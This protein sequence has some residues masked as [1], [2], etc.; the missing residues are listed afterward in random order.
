[1]RGRQRSDHA[2]LIG[3]AKDLGLVL[4]VVEAIEESRSEEE[5]QQVCVCKRPLGPSVEA[6]VDGFE[7]N[8][9]GKING[10]W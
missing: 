7:G 4:R 6:G 5:R 9:G 2:A 3:H 1:M 8:V 10:A